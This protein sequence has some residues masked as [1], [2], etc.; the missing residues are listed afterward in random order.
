MKAL[1]RTAVL[2]ASVGL[3]CGTSAS[4]GG[5]SD[6]LTACT[7]KALTGTFRVV[8][9]S[10]GAGNIVY[11][12]RLRNSSSATCFVTGIPGLTLLDSRDRT[13]PTHPT[14]AHPGALT[15]VL[16]RLAPGSSAR[17]TARFSPDVPGPGEPTARPCE[18]TAEGLRVAPSGGGTLVAPVTPPT[19]V[20]E[21]G[22]MT[23]T[24]LTAA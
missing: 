5:A 24:V 9:G 12:L 1:I 21:H 8:A 14:P 6:P 19:P 15:A 2:V 18:R 10:A 22:G 16:V 20:C 17:A 3:A 11:A 23:M 13:L 7:A 4:P